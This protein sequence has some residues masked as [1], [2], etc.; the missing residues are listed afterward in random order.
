MADKFDE[1]VDHTMKL[2]EHKKPKK[3]ETIID[4]LV[5]STSHMELLSMAP[6]GVIKWHDKHEMCQSDNKR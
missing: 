6:P 4:N 2:Y 5:M 1:L 3:P